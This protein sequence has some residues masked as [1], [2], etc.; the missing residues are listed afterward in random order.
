MEGDECASLVGSRELTSVIKQ[1]VVGRPM[2]GKGR[3][4][5]ALVRT[6]PDRF[7]AVAAVFRGKD[8]LVLSEIKLTIWP[9][10][11]GKGARRNPCDTRA[12]ICGRPFKSSKTSTNRSKLR[13]PNERKR[14]KA[15]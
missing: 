13:T 6:E 12:T 10:V 7:P 1:E 3:D 15:F 14:N 2:S 8:Q 11:I 4:R 5:C 9:A